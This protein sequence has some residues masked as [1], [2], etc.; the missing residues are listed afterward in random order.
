MELFLLATVMQEVGENKVVCTGS[1]HFEGEKKKRKCDA[2]ENTGQVVKVLCMCTAVSGPFLFYCKGTWFTGN[3]SSHT[4]PVS[5]EA[6]LLSSLHGCPLCNLQQLVASS[7]I[8]PHAAGT[9]F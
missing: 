4:M 8:P 2:E 6:R 9:A 5:P 1:E 7:L 3:S